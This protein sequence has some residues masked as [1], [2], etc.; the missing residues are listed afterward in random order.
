MFDYQS[1][2]EG[3]QEDDEGKQDEATVAQE[4]VKHRFT[5]TDQSIVSSRFFKS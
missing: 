2:E 1:D 3:R 4:Q 5:F